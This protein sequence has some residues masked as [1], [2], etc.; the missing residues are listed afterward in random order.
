M[1]ITFLLLNPAL[2]NCLSV[3][4]YCYSDNTQQATGLLQNTLQE[5]VCFFCLIQNGQMQSLS[6]TKTKLNTF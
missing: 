5:S 1:F 6:K 2:A 4:R 3:M